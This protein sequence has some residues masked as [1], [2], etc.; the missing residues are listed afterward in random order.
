MTFVKQILFAT[1][2]TW[3]TTWLCLGQEAPKPAQRPEPPGGAIQ[4]IQLSHVEAGAVEKVIHQLGLPAAVASTSGEKL[5]IRGEED[6]LRRISELVKTLD[7]P[8]TTAGGKPEAYFIALGNTSTATL[9]PAVQALLGERSRVA[10]DSVNGLLVLNAEP[11]EIVAIK[12][13]LATIDRPRVPVAVDFFFLRARIGVQENGGERPLPSALAPIAK[14]LAD[15]GF[16]SLSLMA[17]VHVAADMDREFKSEST[18]RI[19][20]DGRVDDLRFRA[21]GVVRGSG[22][23]EVE[24]TLEAVMSGGYDTPAG[25]KKAGDA[26]FF[27]DTTIAARL[28]QYIVLAASPSSTAQGDAV[29]LVARVT[30]AASP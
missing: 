11:G 10:L 24:L 17:P 25:S 14:T 5:L 12:K 9:M 22:G 18:L 2:L 1:A 29:A 7:V 26:G 4:V 27:I 28:G 8:T 15:N 20:N 3:T 6:V 19:D 21:S 16:A 13:L 30:S 23:D